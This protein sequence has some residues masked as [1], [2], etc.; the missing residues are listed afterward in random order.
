MTPHGKFA[1][2]IMLGASAALSSQSPPQAADATKVGDI[3]VPTLGP[4]QDPLGIKTSATEFPVADSAP[5]RIQPQLKELHAHSLFRS[6]HAWRIQLGRSTR[7]VLNRDGLRSQ[8]TASSISPNRIAAPGGATFCRW[9]RGVGAILILPRG[10]LSEIACLRQQPR[11]KPQLLGGYA[12]GAEVVGGY[13]LVSGA[14]TVSLECRADVGDL[15]AEHLRNLKTEE[16][17]VFETR[18]D[19]ITRNE[20]KF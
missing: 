12:I 4:A 16:G 5:W 8:N 13:A 2:L 18:Q 7:F 6:E 3:E 15:L 10:V 20:G 11:T 17:V 1:L 14:R 9:M 19:R